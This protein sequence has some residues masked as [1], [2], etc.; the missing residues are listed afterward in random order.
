M[1]L[2]IIGPSCDS[3]TLWNLE[4][5]LPDLFLSNILGSFTLYVFLNILQDLLFHKYLG[6]GGGDDKYKLVIYSCGQRCIPLRS[7]N[8]CHLFIPAG[9]GGG[10]GG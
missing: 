10:S 6:G 1:S 4:H 9:N 8:E 3:F 5:E 7:Y 2:N